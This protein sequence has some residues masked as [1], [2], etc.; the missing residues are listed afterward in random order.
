MRTEGG[1][2]DPILDELHA[3]RRQML[4]E[5]DSDLNR[6]VAS[7]QKHEGESGRVFMKLPSDGETKVARREQ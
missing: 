6:L 4:I 7:L 5:C 2:T 3:I 1:Y